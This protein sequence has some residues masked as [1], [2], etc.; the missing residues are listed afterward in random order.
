MTIN[1]VISRF[2]TI[3]F[4]FAGS[5]MTRR[6][7]HLP[8]WEELLRYFAGKISND[9][10]IYQSYENKAGSEECPEGRLPKI[11]SLIETDFNDAWFRN[12]PEVRSMSL[13]VV[14]AVRNGVSPF[15]AELAEY[16]HS[17]MI[18]DEKF[19]F[20]IDK[21]H[22]ISR[23][24][25]SGVITTNYDTFFETLFNDYKTFVGQDEL[26]FSQIQGIAEIYK[27]HGSISD[28]G[29]IVITEDDYSTFREKGKY[30]A[31]KLMTIFL[32]YPVIFIGYSLNDANIQTI[33]ADIVK[34]L[35]ENKIGILKQRLVF[36]NYVPNMVGV[37]VT[38]HSMTIGDKVLEMTRLNLSDFKI[39]YDA[40]SA[41]K[42]SIPVK[43]LRRFKEDLYQYAITNTPSTTLRVAQL[44]DDR[45]DDDML[46]L[47]IGL[48]DTGVYG[49]A[50]AVTAD[51]WYRSIVL[52]DLRQFTSHDLLQYAYLDIAKQNSWKLPVWKMLRDVDMQEFPDAYERAPK[53]YVDIVQE[54]SIRGNN[55]NQY[56]TISDLW[57]S[58][59]S[60]IPRALRLMTALPRAKVDAEKVYAILTE[61][62][63]DADALT[64]LESP[65]RSNLR[66]L[67]RI[68]DFLKWGEK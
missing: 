53:T 34:C 7:Y 19:H 49:L 31:A 63:V 62:F 15:K 58:E 6:Y 60:N 20:E 28:A 39:L 16:I 67:I 66:K 54:G 55:S 22:Q 13:F 42:A 61:I 10:F 52:D 14:D 2:N 57:Q 44:D 18:V 51:K 35:P 56:N 12:K 30:L 33:L 21:L 40:L 3:P 9:E 8:N 36:V 25:I 45:I 50:K 41:K 43:V 5:G 37:E 4:L 59:K 24:N 38:S 29:S 48:S 32:E 26:V 65:Y 17:R 47:N 64:N 1:D 68:Y 46:A 11:A 23:A 27:I